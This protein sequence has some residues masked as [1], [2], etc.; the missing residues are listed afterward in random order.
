MNGETI[1]IILVGAGVGLYVSNKT[2]GCIERNAAEVEKQRIE[3]PIKCQQHCKTL[4]AKASVNTESN[5]QQCFCVL[6]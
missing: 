3:F 1:F 5:P 2:G 6:P 4:N